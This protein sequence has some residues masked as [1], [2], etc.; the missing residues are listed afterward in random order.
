MGAHGLQHALQLEGGVAH[1]RQA[2]S[3]G[4]AGDRMRGAQQLVAARIAAARQLVPEGLYM[5]QFS[6]QLARVFVAH[7][8]KQLL[9]RGLVQR[10]GDFY[11]LKVEDLESLERYGRKSA[12]N[13]Y[14]AIQRSRR[15]PLARI[16]NGLGIPQ[17]GEQTAIDLARWVADQEPPGEDWLRR[18]GTFLRSV[19]T[20][21]PDR[22]LAVEGVGPNVAAG[23]A[24]YFADPTTAEIVEDLAE[25]GVEAEPPPARPATAGRGALDGK[26]VV[27]TGTL[28]G[29]T[30]P[31]AEEAIRAAG[32]KAGGSVSRKTDYLVAGENAGSKLARAEELG[33]PVL[34]EAAFRQMLAGEAAPEPSGTS[35]DG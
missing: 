31:E 8:R 5:R 33:V 34:D 26:T 18:A 29:F 16:L 19:A 9:Q 21:D 32:G 24:A 3:R 28:P 12:E 30:R 14:E 4:R 2:E 15:R 7:V 17:V 22:F 6:R 20:Q 13:L 1:A 23:L 27:V 35:G 11:R 10:R 25:A